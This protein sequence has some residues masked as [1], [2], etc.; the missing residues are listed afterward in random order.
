MKRI[1]EKAKAV[2][3]GVF[4]VWAMS[5]AYSE[6][7]AQTSGGPFAY[8]SNFTDHTVSV[9]DT[10]TNTVTATIPL[11]DGFPGTQRQGDVA[12]LSHFLLIAS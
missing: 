10:V 3:L 5:N 12:H 6:V 2:S 1:R 7:Y 9:I 11:P 8:I 4:L